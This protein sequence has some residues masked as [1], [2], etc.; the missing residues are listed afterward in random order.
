MQSRFGLAA[1]TLLALTPTAF[2]YF[3]RTTRTRA[4]SMASNAEQ[5][6]VVQEDTVPQQK[7]PVPAPGAA[8][9]GLRPPFPFPNRD[10]LAK[11]QAKSGGGRIKLPVEPPVDS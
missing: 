4:A 5:P 11:A 1:L 10:D 9:T 3:T 2:F 8:S 6:Q 7:T